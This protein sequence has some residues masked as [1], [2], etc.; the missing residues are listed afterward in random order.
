MDVPRGMPPTSVH[1]VLGRALTKEHLETPAMSAS[2]TPGH[3]R[4]RV[5][6]SDTYVLLDS[7]RKDPTRSEPSR[8]RYSFNLDPDG[9]TTAEAIGTS[10]KLRDTFELIA[11]PFH[12]PLPLQTTL[13]PA[14]HDE[15]VV[16]V[17]SLAS[18]VEFP[19]VAV[20]AATTAA[21]PAV[22]YDNGVAGV[23]ATLTADAL[24]ALGTQD[25][26]AIGLNDRLLVK[27]QSAALQNGVYQLSTVGDGATAFVLTRTTDADSE[28][29]LLG[30]NFIPSGGATYSDTRFYINE[31]TLDIGTDDI[32]WAVYNPT[33]TAYADPIVSS[34]T[35]LS[36]PYAPI[37]LGG[38][39]SMFV[40]EVPRQSYL[41]IEGRSHHVEF[42]A[43]IVTGAAVD[44]SGETQQCL[45]LEPLVA[46]LGRF[47]FATPLRE[48]GH[49]EVEFRGA[50]EDLLQFSPDVFDLLFD[51]SGGAPRMYWPPTTI[52]ELPARPTAAGGGRYFPLQ[53]GDRVYISGLAA[54][55]AETPA[56]PIPRFSDYINRPAGHLVASLTDTGDGT[57][58]FFVGLFPAITGLPAAS[59]GF[60]GGLGTTTT[61]QV[62]VARHRL[63]IPLRFRSLDSAAE[64]PLVAV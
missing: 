59:I 37:P 43:R 56:V 19:D 12:I 29:G 9:S 11:D 33:V 32:D 34:A 23:G 20:A 44:G 57:G 21:L 31:L 27:D 40:R 47:I 30:S 17:A 55:T 60:D 4:H 2:V 48:L 61:V 62:R 38:R 50:G 36:H 14:A 15:A 58:N 16:A 18:A 25:G 13:G 22:T 42:T 5:G 1:E 45:H 63:R 3:F 6:I 54:N 52:G 35:V 53:V 7:W 28:T 51:L 49:L 24:G 8:G 39:V 46:T 10:R 26:V 64:N 41:G